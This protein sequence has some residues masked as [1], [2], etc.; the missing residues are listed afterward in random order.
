M[1]RDLIPERDFEF[2]RLCAEPLLLEKRPGQQTLQQW[3][4]FETG[5][6]NELVKIRAARKKIEPAKYLRADA[7]FDQALHLIA[8]NSHRILSPLETERF[9]DK[10]RWQKLEDMSAGHYFDLDFLVIYALKLLILLRW[11]RIVALDKA[12]AIEE[13]TAQV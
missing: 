3:I 12:R 2:V 7:Q 10:E 9:L 13:L 8:M 4:G 1:C 6:R 5:L 11:E